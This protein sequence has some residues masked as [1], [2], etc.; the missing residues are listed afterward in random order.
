MENTVLQ[1]LDNLGGRNSSD[2]T[3]DRAMQKLL[4]AKLF[5]RAVVTCG[6][7]YFEGGGQPF[8]INEVA[9]QLHKI[10]SNLGSN[11]VV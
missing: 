5:P 8:P 11:K 10:V 6:V 9:N 4:R 7:V 2:E 3:D 1:W